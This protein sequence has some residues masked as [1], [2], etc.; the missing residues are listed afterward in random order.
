M[1]VVYL[2]SPI[3]V[4]GSGFAQGLREASDTIGTAIKI[5]T[6]RECH[7]IV[8]TGKGNLHTLACT[9]LSVC[10]EPQVKYNV[11]A[12]AREMIVWG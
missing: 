12:T 3:W 5:Q 8:M 7:E 4:S 2:L 10:L 11:R 9:L 1:T 6:T